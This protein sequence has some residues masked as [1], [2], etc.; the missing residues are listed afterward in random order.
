M[1]CQVPCSAVSFSP[2][3]GTPEIVGGDDADWL[4]AP[5]PAI[6]CVAFESALVEPSEFFAVTSKRSV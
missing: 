4:A 5:S 1:P 2:T 6:S 3:T